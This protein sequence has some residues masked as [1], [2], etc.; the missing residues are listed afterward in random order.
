VK[1]RLLDRLLRAVASGMVDFKD[2][3]LCA[4]WCSPLKEMALV[5]LMIMGDSL[6]VGRGSG[7]VDDR[8]RCRKP[9][10]LGVKCGWREMK[11]ASETTMHTMSLKDEFVQTLEQSRRG[12]VDEPR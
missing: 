8:C 7:V 2:G 6:A 4:G 11:R 3:L 1:T 12:S 10:R 5:R 9:A